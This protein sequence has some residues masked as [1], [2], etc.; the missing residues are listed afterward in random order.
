[1]ADHL[2]AGVTAPSGAVLSDLVRVSRSR[3]A[4]FGSGRL[5]TGDDVEDG[6]DID[7]QNRPGLTVAADDALVIADFGVGSSGVGP[8]V[9]FAADDFFPAPPYAD[10]VLET[11]GEDAG[12]AGIP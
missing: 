9:G 8:V 4:R 1:M 12:E 6:E 5:R 2:P 11:P 7:C 10:A 3:R